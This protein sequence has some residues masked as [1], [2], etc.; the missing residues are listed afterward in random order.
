MYD[1]PKEYQVA[2]RSPTRTDRLAGKLTLADGSTIELTDSA[3]IAGSLSVDNQCVS[4]QELAFGGVYMGQAS[5]QLRTQLSSA[6]FYDAAL[7]IDYQLRL[8]DGSWY[9]LPVGRY[10]VAE[11]ERSAAVVSLTAYDHMLKLQRSLSG[12]V[13]LGDA[14]AML[15]Q[16]A[17]ACGVELGQT[18]E[19]INALS[20]N[21]ALQRQLDSSYHVS[22]W[23]DCAGAVAQLLAGFATFDRLGRLVVRQF[24]ESPCV[25][26]AENARTSAK[27]SDF[28][29]HYAALTIETG[30]DAYTAGTEGDT[31][32]EMTISDMP[33][34]ES[35]LA[36]V[37]QEICDALYKKLHALDYT[38][39]TVTLPGDPALELGDRLALPTQTAAP[40]TLVTHL[41]WKF[42]AAETL[43]GVGKNPYLAG[44]ATRTD[45]QLRSLQRQADANKIMYY[46]FT[47]GSDLTVKSDGREVNAANLTFVTT[48]DTSAMFLAQVLLDA[49]PESVTVEQSVSGGDAADD[50]TAGDDAASG[51]GISVALEQDAA[52]TL[53]VRYYMDNLLIESF[54]PV[55]RLVRGAHALALF[56]PFPDLA[57]AASHRWSVRLLCEGGEVKIAKG[58]IRATISGQGMAAADAWDGTLEFEELVGRI[59][60]PVAGIRQV[61]APQERLA[62]AVDMPIGGAFADGI[63]VTKRVARQRRIL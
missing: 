20:P 54:V 25:T 5:L 62:L 14:Y 43:K 2:I 9:T 24:G 4:G 46:S 17:E 26:L 42:R 50:S 10:T 6:A 33:L 41:V 48:Q 22:T 7:E 61:T 32:L 52:L 31:G 49:Q 30:D 58:Q 56:Y 40:E 36:S 8:P 53:T 37:K 13:L 3:V 29:C 1:V 27:I 12:S 45:P 60:R 23:R 51:E 11:A 55:Q 19:E 18:E 44:A 47:N 21:A 57:G 16:I 34:A 39:A 35:G 28:S 63:G 38:P 15:A 59:E